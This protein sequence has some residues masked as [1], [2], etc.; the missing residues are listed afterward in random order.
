MKKL[1]IALYNIQIRLIDY[2]LDDPD[3]DN[4]ERT[5]L[6]V[7]KRKMSN[8]LLKRGVLVC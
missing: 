2:L 7:I 6:L 4:E 1:M 3:C 8:D 5:E